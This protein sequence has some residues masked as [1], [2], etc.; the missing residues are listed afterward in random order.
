M[1]DPVNVLVVFYSRYGETER[2]A[3]QIDGL[4]ERTDLLQDDVVGERL[5]F[6]RDPPKPGRHDQQ[7]VRRF[8]RT[9]PT[10]TP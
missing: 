9:A 7:H 5:V 10:A 8:S 3:D 1:A 2:L 6:A 4:V